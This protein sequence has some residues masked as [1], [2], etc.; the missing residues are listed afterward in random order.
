MGSEKTGKENRGTFGAYLKSLRNGKD[1]SLRDVEE[2][3]NKE[4][5]NAY[6]SQLENNR[7]SKPSPNILY[8]LSHI[9]SVSYEN[10]MERAG[11]IA[12]RKEEGKELKHGKA[13]TFAID[14]LN[15]DEESELLNY[16][17]WYREKKKRP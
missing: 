15:A 13:A 17:A 10:L 5:S 7:I 9:Y 16:L 8:R 6:L 3:T 1:L 2:A 4:I 12:P 14:N 11:Y